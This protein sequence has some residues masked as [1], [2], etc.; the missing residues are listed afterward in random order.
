MGTRPN[1][2]RKTRAAL[3][4][5][6]IA[7]AHPPAGT[8]QD[9]SGEESFDVRRDAW[10]FSIPASIW[11]Q[12]IE[13]DRMG[14]RLR[15]SGTFAIQPF[16]DVGDISLDAIQVGAF[17]PGL[18][19]LI[20]LSDHSLL[21]PYADIGVGSASGEL[22][23]SAMVFGGGMRGEFVFPWHRFALGIEPRIALAATRASR[24]AGDDEFGTAY[25]RFDARYP[26]WFKTG[27][28]IPEMGAYVEPGYSFRDFTAASIIGASQDVGY[29]FEA[30]ASFGFRGPYP[31]IWFLTIP[32]I[33]FGY[34]WGSGVR[35]WV[36]RLG[37]DR[38]TRLRW[39]DVPGSGGWGSN[40][41]Q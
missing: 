27:S 2:F 20:P 37:G 5:A 39:D 14:I 1:R 40:Y 34:R 6:V 3:V 17:V 23:G 36:I 31:K 29:E 41:H 21:R 38:V 16:D 13:R 28:Y 10:I 22:L 35:G 24:D 18:E 15:L 9:L 30:G 25:A 33:G 4:V 26:L 19:L 32:R 8:A 7:A 12:R 11:L